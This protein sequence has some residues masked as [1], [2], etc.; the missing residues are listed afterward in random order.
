MTLLVNNLNSSP[1]L[2]LTPELTLSSKQDIQQKMTAASNPTSSSTLNDKKTTAIPM[3]SET[4]MKVDL[5]INQ[6]E[7]KDSEKEF[8]AYFFKTMI[9]LSKNEKEEFIAGASQALS[10]RPDEKV[11]SLNDRFNKA[12]KR[13]ISISLMSAPISEQLNRNIGQIKLETD[14]EDD[15]EII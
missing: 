8:F 2:T 13:Y 14:D 9:H 7:Q 4:K 6:L 1:L 12:L 15:V 10:S 3:S 5:F 11:P